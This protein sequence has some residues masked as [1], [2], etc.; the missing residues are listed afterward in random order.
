[1]RLYDKIIWLRESH[2]TLIITYPKEKVKS[3]F[4]TLEK[5]G[6]KRASKTIIFTHLTPVLN[7]DF[8]TKKLYSKSLKILKKVIER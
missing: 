8:T 1:M 7:K 5:Y 3:S 4:L 2:L 6:F